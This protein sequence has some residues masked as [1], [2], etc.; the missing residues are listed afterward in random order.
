MSGGFNFGWAVNIGKKRDVEIGFDFLQDTKALGKSGV[1]SVLV[2]GGGEV[3]WSFLS[4][5]LAQRVHAFLA[6][7]VLG[8]RDAVPAV[9]G[10]GFASPQEGV[11]LKFVEVRR[12]DG[13]L[14]IVAEVE[15]V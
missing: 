4:E 2:E 5:G 9:G 15:G 7:L 1:S 11:R 8:G 3:H 10:D 12:L 13:D 14:V 6:P